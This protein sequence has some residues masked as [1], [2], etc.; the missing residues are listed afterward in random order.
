MTGRSLVQI[1]IDIFAGSLRYLFFI[2][3]VKTEQLLILEDV[4]DRLFVPL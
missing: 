4:T 1:E 3:R 2:E